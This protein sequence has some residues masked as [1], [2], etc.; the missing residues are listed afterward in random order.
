MVFSLGT[1][2]HLH[3]SNCGWEHRGIVT[4]AASQHLRD[5]SSDS[6]RGCLPNWA[7]SAVQFK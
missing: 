1:Y 4:S 2:L 3:L 7:V 6:V 5:V